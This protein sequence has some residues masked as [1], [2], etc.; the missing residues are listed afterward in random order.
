MDESDSGGP[1]N[2]KQQF[3]GWKLQYLKRFEEY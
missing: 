3:K 1:T 2:E